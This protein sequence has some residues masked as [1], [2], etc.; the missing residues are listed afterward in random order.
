[1]D[2]GVMMQVLPP[3]VEQRDH[4][5]LGAQVSGICAQGPQ[6]LGC[7][8]EQDGVERRLVLEG[9]L[10]DLRRHR[11]D[12]VE[13][14]NWQQVGLPR[15]EPVG[16]SQTLTL[17]TMPIAAGVIGLAHQAAV[18]A[19]LGVTAQG[20]SAAGFDGAHD[21]PLDA[22]EVTLMGKAIRRAVAAEDVRHLQ[23]RAHEP[24]QAGGTTSTCS[25]SSGLTVLPIVC[26]AT[27]V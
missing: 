14:L 11:E 15:V 1:M 26:V 21:A 23:G 10:G 27:W 24:A 17:R 8:L 25:R 16:A 12:D 2:V 3:S 20:R 4:A 5:E 19:V 18:C 13:V 9:D 6:R 7:R 22:P